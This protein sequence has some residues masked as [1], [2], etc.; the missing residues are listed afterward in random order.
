MCTISGTVLQRNLQHL[1]YDS[2]DLLNPV[3]VKPGLDSG[4]CDGD[5]LE[6]ALCIP[7]GHLV[8]LGD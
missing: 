7:R 6:H 4:L 1:L 8:G 5:V 3:G 2:A